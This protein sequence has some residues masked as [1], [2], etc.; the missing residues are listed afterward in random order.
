MDRCGMP[1][2]ARPLRL[3]GP[4]TIAEMEDAL[5]YVARLVSAGYTVY[6]PIMDRLIED[7]RVARRADPV[8]RAEAVLAAYNRAGGLNAIRAMNE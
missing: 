3:Q 2:P 6:T 8:A 7:L 4:P 5:V 1:L